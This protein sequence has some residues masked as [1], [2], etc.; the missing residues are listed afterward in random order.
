MLLSSWASISAVFVVMHPFCQYST[1]LPLIS[2]SW[3]S[4]PVI[5]RSDSPA[6]LHPCKPRYLSISYLLFSQQYCAIC[7]LCSGILT[8][9]WLFRTACA[10]LLWLLCFALL[11]TQR[12]SSS[13][14]W[15]AFSTPRCLIFLH[16]PLLRFGHL[17]SFPSYLLSLIC[18]LCIC[19][20]QL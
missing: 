9:L 1:S 13:L 4:I 19:Y 10:A 18:L 5:A 7:F 16:F 2:I 15:P 8:P 6:S 14:I 17:W 3:I 11:N 20:S 12:S